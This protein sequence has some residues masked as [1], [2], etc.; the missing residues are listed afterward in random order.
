MIALA[1]VPALQFTAGSGC[2]S[3]SP[4][5]VVVWGGVA[6][7]PRRAGRTCATAPRR[8]TR[9]SRSARSP[10]TC[11]R[12]TRWCSATPATPGM[13]RLRA[14]RRPGR[15]GGERLPR[16]RRGG[17]RVPAGR[18]LLRGAGQAPRRRRAAAR[19]SSSAPRTSRCCATASRSAMPGRRSCA[20][21]DQFVVRPGE[22]IATD[23]VVVDGQLGGRREHAHRRVGA[24]RGRRR[25]TRSSARR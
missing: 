1:M 21:G 14:A 7:P 10:R 19:C 4:T 24:G 11:G 3:R 5:P 18:A 22:K 17:D 9:W 23:G 25:A 16:G 8:W 2:R 13:R 6:V 20:V 15:R 12:C